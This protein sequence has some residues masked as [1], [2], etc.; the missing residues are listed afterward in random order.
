MSE[1]FQEMF[2]EET[3]E[4]IEKMNENLLSLEEDPTDLELIEEIYRASHTLKGMAGTMGYQ[5]IQKISHRME[6]LFDDLK[7]EGAKVDERLFEL[8]FECV[9][10]IEILSTGEEED[11]QYLIDEL[12]DVISDKE[13]DEETEI[14]RTDLIKNTT[15]PERIKESLH[16]L[17]EKELTL[18]MIKV[19]EDEELPAVR[20]VELREKLDFEYELFWP[21]PED[22][23]SDRDK[24]F[25]VTEEELKKKDLDRTTGLTIEIKRD[26]G[27]KLVKEKEDMK[28]EKK[29]DNK[30]RKITTSDKLKVDLEDIEHVMNL[31]SELVISKG[32]LEDLS[33]SLDSDRLSSVTNRVDRISG[34]LRESVL[35][36]KMTEVKSVFRRFPRMVR[37][38]AKEKDK[39]VNF[40]MKGEDIELDRTILERITDPLVHLLRNAV[41]HGIEP[42]EERKEKGKPPE[43]KIKLAATQ[44][45]E[46]VLI[47]ISDDGRGL[48]EEKIKEKAFERG[49]IDEEEIEEIPEEDLYM[50]V[51]NSHFTTKDEVTEV[52][53][54]GVGMEVVKETMDSLG[55]EVSIR[56]EK[57]E[58]T[59]IKLTLP[60]SVAIVQAFLIQV[61]DGTYAVSLE[62]IVETA[63]VKIEDIE[64]IKG[65]DFISLRDKYIPLIY[66]R[67]KFDDVSPDSIKNEKEKLT[68]TIVSKEGETAGFVIDEVLTEKEIVIKP[69]P[70]NLQNMGGFMGA[71]IL[72]DGT[73]AM[74]LDTLYWIETTA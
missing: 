47:E 59:T 21:D 8:L 13:D 10:T 31:I 65:K 63:Q 56:S 64:K 25:V 5:G 35:D 73:I 33:S 50:L 37:D 38:I 15:L 68:V 51:F 19:S 52:S 7:N 48:D 61:G 9:D 20:G 11:Y 57:G 42:I 53:G 49:L 30:E 2:E 36:L 17:S 67:E 46:N 3:R 71:T 18:G 27:K 66:L 40:E 1:D 41:D 58:G 12:D 70:E 60:P 23:D 62:D 29:E 43:G 69:L 32:S 45:E 4:Q 24:F 55:G 26:E 22:V 74:I 44:K 39:K 16:R 72:G 14:D 6:E 34:E 54:R 28:A